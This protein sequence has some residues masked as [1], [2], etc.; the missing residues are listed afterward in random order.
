MVIFILKNGVIDIIGGVIGGYL[1][2]IYSSSLC[3]LSLK[4]FINS[5]SF[6]SLKEVIRFSKGSWIW[7]LGLLRDALGEEMLFR[8]GWLYYLGG[9][10]ISVMLSGVI[11]A[12]THMRIP[13]YRHFLNWLDYFT[14]SL[15][16]SLTL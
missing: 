7:K 13:H 6:S 11:F 12:F 16:L 9:S 15:I 14:I 1:L 3:C 4:C 5:V 2:Y 8:F 10:T